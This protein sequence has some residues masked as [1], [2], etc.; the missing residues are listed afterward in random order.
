MLYDVI[1]I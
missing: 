1:S